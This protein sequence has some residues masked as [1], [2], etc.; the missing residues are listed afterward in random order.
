MFLQVTFW[1]VLF[2]KLLVSD[3]EQDILGGML[4]V[5]A[6]KLNSW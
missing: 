2:L 1:P 5:S 6:Q 4:F 3:F